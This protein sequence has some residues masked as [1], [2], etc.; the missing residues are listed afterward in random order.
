MNKN[1]VLK[2]LKDIE[3]HLGI[4]FPSE[5]MKFISEEVQDKEPYEIKNKKGDC[6]YIFNYKDIV[7]RNETYTVRDAEPDYFLIGQD[8]DLGYFIC[9]KDNSD[10]IYSVD[11]GALGSLNMD[12]EAKDLYDL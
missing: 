1:K 2:E 5:Y 6:I 9:L 3:K 8:G 4:K 12:D 11:L 10:T 7:E